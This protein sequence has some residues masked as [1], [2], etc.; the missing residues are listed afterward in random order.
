MSFVKVFIGRESINI[1]SF[2]LEV[3]IGIQRIICGKLN[4][5]RKWRLIDTKVPVDEAN[6]RIFFHLISFWETLDPSF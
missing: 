3:Q 6:R 4:W 1:S 2:C 5:L